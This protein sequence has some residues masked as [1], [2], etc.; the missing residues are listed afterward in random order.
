[1]MD[2]DKARMRAAVM[3]AMLVNEHT[4]QDHKQI[5]DRASAT[6]GWQMT[7]STAAG[8]LRGMENAGLVRRREYHERDDR[9]T[10]AGE[11]SWRQLTAAG[12]YAAEIMRALLEGE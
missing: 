1:M 12:R 6:L 5:G 4:M 2:R 10:A 8:I 7:G 11:G 3:T 9:G